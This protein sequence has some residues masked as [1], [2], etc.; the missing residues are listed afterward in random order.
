MKKDFDGWNTQKKILDEDRDVKLYHERQIWWCVLGVNVGF[1]QDGTGDGYQRPVLI[2]K[3]MS[4]ETCYVVPL[5]TS[6]KKHRLRIPIGLVEDQQ[7]VAIMSQMRLIDTKG[8]VDKVGFL[9][10]ETF[11]QIQKAAKNLF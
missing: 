10:Q 4:R 1:E 9:N 11:A 8:L 2:L 5:T 6:T 3:A 7:A